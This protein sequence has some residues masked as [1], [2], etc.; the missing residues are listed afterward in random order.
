M[1]LFHLS[2]N[3]HQRSDLISENLLRL[4]HSTL[5]LHNLLVHQLINLLHV[6]KHSISLLIQSFQLL[7]VVPKLVSLVQ[8]RF[9]G[10][11]SGKFNTLILL[12]GIYGS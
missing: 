11:V 7:L 4:S 5:N 8:Y 10:R 12:R 2:L 9:G 6:L 3:S 1:H